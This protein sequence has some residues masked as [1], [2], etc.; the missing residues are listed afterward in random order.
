[1]SDTKERDIVIARILFGDLHYLRDK[2]FN[3]EGMDKIISHDLD[4]LIYDLRYYLAQKGE[5]L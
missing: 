2:F 5:H 1:M 4:T 3:G